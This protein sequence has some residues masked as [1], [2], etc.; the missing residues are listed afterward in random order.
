M[1]A[2][3]VHA[4]VLAAGAGR[5]L[6]G[7]VPKH[8]VAV[9]GSPMLEHVLR[10]LLGSRVISTTVVVRADDTPGAV[11]A[12]R[13][14]AAVC[15]PEDP[16]EG[17]AASIRAGAAA[18]PQDV[19]GLLFVPADQPR[20]ESADFDAL[21][22][23]HATGADIAHASYDGVRGTPVLFAVQHRPRLLALRGEEGGRVLLER[24]PAGRVAVALPPAHGRD[25]DT[26]EDL[27]ALESG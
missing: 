22:D 13:L 3:T 6:G 24:Y 8:L 14:G 9:R 18:A 5:R 23:A 20:L 27:A 25:V 26:P 21:V 2:P 11:L 1:T 19:T 17:R 12:R 15:S 7:A 16:G 4:V 10:A